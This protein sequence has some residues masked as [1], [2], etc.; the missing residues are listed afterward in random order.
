[1]HLN[2]QGLTTN[3]NELEAFVNKHEPWIICLTETHITNE[4]EDVEIK[5]K[6]YTHIRCNS[7]SRHTGGVI[8]YVSKELEY[9]NE[10]VFAK[11]YNYWCLTCH[12]K[13]NNRTHS[14]TGVYHSPNGNTNEFLEFYEH[15]VNDMVERERNIIVVGDFNIDWNEDNRY[16]RTLKR[17]TWDA[18]LRQMI[19]NY[20]RITNSSASTTDLVFTNIE[21]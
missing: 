13:V 9:E 1:M 19:R 3:K 12:I 8:L 6:G 17:I 11:D 18:E 21:N 20:T 16:P 14:L 5:L 10:R 7:N 15:F 4:I 2:I